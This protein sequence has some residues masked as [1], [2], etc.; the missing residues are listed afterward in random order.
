MIIFPR[1]AKRLP[2]GYEALYKVKDCLVRSTWSASEFN[3]GMEL[4]PTLLCCY[5]SLHGYL[6]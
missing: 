5:F 3:I 2:A 4:D 1:K 6:G